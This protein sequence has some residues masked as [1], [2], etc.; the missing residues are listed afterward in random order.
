MN[1]NFL[2]AAF[3]GASI[4]A[5]TTSSS[6]ADSW[7]VSGGAGLSMLAD[8]EI[9]STEGADSASGKISHDN[10]FAMM[11]AIGKTFGD[12]RLEGELSYRKNDLDTISYT[13]ATIDGQTFAVSESAGAG[14]DLASL[15]F[16]GNAYYD[17]NNNSAWTPFVMAGVGMA[18]HTLNIDSLSGEALNYDESD[19]VFAYQ[20]GAGVGYSVTEK[21]KVT[22]Q[23]RL[24]GAADATF[25][26]GAEKTEGDYMN[27]SIMVGFTHS[28]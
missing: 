16:M 15:A 25:D 12:F 9:T 11:G 21:D 1:K 19:T 7:Y 18:H 28:F 6:A 17:L 24:L 4:L 23:Y 10:G 27:H 13:S 2:C 22:L 8:S 5:F 14:G 20:I 3:A 26:D